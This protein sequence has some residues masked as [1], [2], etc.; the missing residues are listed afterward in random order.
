MSDSPRAF[1]PRDFLRS[2]ALR[3]VDVVVRPGRTA[4]CEGRSYSEG[5]TFR[6]PERKARVLMLLGRVEQDLAGVD[7]GH[8]TSLAQPTKVDVVET[9][10]E[11][12]STP[13]RRGRPY[14]RRDMVAEQ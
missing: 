8:R 14:K 3:Y 7:T 10:A 5:Q 12:R 1:S 13:K 2:D 9:L 11:Q 4:K 6:A